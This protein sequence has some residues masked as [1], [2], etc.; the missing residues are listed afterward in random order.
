[1]HLS[2]LSQNQACMVYQYK[3]LIPTVKHGEEGEMMFAYFTAPR[4]WVMEKNKNTNVNLQWNEKQKK[5][6]QL[7]RP[8]P[9][10]IEMVWLGPYDSY[11]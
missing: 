4:L 8:R 6:S 5:K 1:M 9:Q 10:P 3:H 7:G 2:T 11:A